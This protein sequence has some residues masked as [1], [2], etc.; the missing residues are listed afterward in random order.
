MHKMGL[1]HHVVPENKGVLKI[2]HAH[3]HTCMHTGS[4]MSKEHR[5]Q[6]KEL[7][8]GKLGNIWNKINKT[9]FYYNTK[10]ELNIHESIV[11]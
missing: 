2:T 11:I 10:Y 6:L 3:T 5:N 9:S 4:D 8:T 7:S 1:E